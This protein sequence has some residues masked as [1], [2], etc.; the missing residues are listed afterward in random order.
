M[1]DLSAIYGQEI[2]ACTLNFF[3]V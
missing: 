2:C 1:T 3:Y